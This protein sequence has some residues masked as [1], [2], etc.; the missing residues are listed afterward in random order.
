MEPFGLSSYLNKISQ[1]LTE[2]TDSAIVLELSELAILFPSSGEN[3]F[4]Q[5]DI[6]YLQRSLSEAGLSSEPDISK[7]YRKLD[8]SG[9]IVVF[10]TTFFSAYPIEALLREK[11][12]FAAIALFAKADGV[13]DKDELD[14]IH[15]CRKHRSAQSGISLG[16]ISA[17]SELA[18]TERQHELSARIKGL[19]HY[20]PS[21][22]Q[23]LE[24]FANIII[25][26]GHIDRREVFTYRDIYD[27]T[28]G[29]RL[30]PGEAKNMLE[31]HA[32]SVHKNIGKSRD[33][34]LDEPNLYNSL[35]IDDN[36]LDQIFSDF[37]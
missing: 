27:L 22:N 13:L 17:I 29:I 12:F 30:T 32:K 23:L 14:Y 2:K 24:F 26:D 35:D 34:D 6:Y 11:I 18:L 15:F 10:K 4:S 5:D 31:V 36:V 37:L 33:N 20:F 9:K 1:K 19:N 3:P 7:H 25:S 16:K 21:T 28:T 8:L